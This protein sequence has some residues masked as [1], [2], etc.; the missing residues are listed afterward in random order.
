[1]AGLGEDWAGDQSASSSASR[2][3]EPS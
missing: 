3:A 2:R 1:M